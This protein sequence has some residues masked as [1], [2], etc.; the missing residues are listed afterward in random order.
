MIRSWIAIL[1]IPLP[2]FSRSSEPPFSQADSDWTYK[3]FYPVL[4][5]L[6]PMQGTAGSYVVYRGHSE[7]DVPEYWFAIG[8][9]PNQDGHGSQKYLSAHIR[10]ADTRSIFGQ[11]MRAHRSEP[12]DDI[13]S[14]QKRIKLR[15]FELN[16]MTCPAMKDQVGILTQIHVNVPTFG[17]GVFVFGHPPRSEFHIQGDNGEQMSVSLLEDDKLPHQNALLNWVFFTR[18]ALDG[19]AQVR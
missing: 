7:S 16:E 2:F 3:H 14:I 17:E 18:R 13:A 19:C 11:I 4:D 10:I 1:L 8:Y 5:E 9:D 15:T 6:M 12:R